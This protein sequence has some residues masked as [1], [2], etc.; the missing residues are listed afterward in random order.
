M[1]VWAKSR[2]RATSLFASIKSFAHAWLMRC[3]SSAVCAAMSG[4]LLPTIYFAEPRTA[5]SCCLSFSPTGWSLSFLRSLLICMVFTRFAQAFWWQWKNWKSHLFDPIVS[6]KNPCLVIQCLKGN[7]SLI[8]RT[9]CS[10]KTSEPP[11]TMLSTWRAKT[12]WRACSWK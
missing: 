7:F 12:P 6:Q 5:L 4:L 1:V 2:I 9:T 8:R 3:W 11:R 10:M